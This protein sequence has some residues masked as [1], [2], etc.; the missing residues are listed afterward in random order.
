MEKN[1]ML[2]ISLRNV[3]N[4]GYP[5]ADMPTFMQRF[6]PRLKNLDNW[7]IGEASKK[8]DREL[9]QKKFPDIYFLIDEKGW[10][11]AVNTAPNVSMNLILKFATGMSK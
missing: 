2:I 11:R 9:N 3:D 4:G 10:V 8:M 7:I 5:G 1:G 6:A